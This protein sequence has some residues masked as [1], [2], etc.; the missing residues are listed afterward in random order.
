MKLKFLP[1]PQRSFFPYFS[2]LVKNLFPSISSKKRAMKNDST[3]GK[4][5]NNIA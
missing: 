2:A 3:F 1:S 5:S 4:Y